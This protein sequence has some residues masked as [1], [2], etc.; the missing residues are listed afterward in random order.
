MLHAANRAR[1]R[2]EVLLLD[3][4][5]E[6]MNRKI[7]RNEARFVST[8]STSRT[9]WLVEHEGRVYAAVYNKNLNCIATFLPESIVHTWE[10]AIEGS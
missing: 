9:R 2:Y 7:Q 4:D 5:I 8:Q 1:M 3:S 6:A 10:A